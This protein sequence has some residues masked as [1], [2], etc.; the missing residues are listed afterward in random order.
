MS[1]LIITCGIPGVG[2]STW[3]K[4]HESSFNPSHSI[5]S[6]DQIR[7]S[8]LK[9]GEY[10]FSHEEEVWAQFIEEIKISLC[11]NAETYV[12]ATHL[13]ERARA[14]LFRAI[15]PSLYGVEL[16][17]LYF[18][19]PLSVA[20][21]QNEFRSGRAY[22]HPTSIISMH[23]SLTEPTFEE[24]FNKIYIIKEDGKLYQKLELEN[25]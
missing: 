25:D 2:K 11:L 7:F 20:L 14:K 23:S 24:G 12:D 6:R 8:M 13:N 10:Y 4:K 9:D 5:I 19:K 17:V 3:L 16:E 15:G 22:V 1:K 21:L 18:D